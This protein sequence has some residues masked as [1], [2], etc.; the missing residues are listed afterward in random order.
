MPKEL[1]QEILGLELGKNIRSLRIQKALTLQNLSD[2]TGLSKPLLSQ[3]ENDIAAPP[4]AT[5]L[6]IARAL[7]VH[8]GYFFQDNRVAERISVVRRDEQHNVVDH[9]RAS[10]SEVG[11]RYRLLVHSMP[12][13]QMEPFLVEIE[14]RSENELV[15]YNHAG[16]EFLYV[17]AGSLE[18]R[19][20]DRTIVLGPGDSLYFDSQIPHA[21]RGL[22]GKKARVL[23]VIYSAR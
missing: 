6:K 22:R 14:P 13:R 17:L 3:I 1:N 18:Y 23:A 21:V 2:L 10:A 5:L 7:G 9:S 15:F 11:Y 12:D 4:I 20:G 8:I 16:E 19:G